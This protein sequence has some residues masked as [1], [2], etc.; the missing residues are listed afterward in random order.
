MA[1]IYI[2]VHPWKINPRVEMSYPRNTASCLKYY[3]R[4]I[5]INLCHCSLYH[6]CTSNKRCN[7]QCMY[8]IK[9]E[10][11]DMYVPMSLGDAPVNQFE[12]I[13]RYASSDREIVYRSG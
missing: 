9:V 6:T 3:H 8:A 12:I 7:P 13:I 10:V 11:A 1:G 2:L 4:Q 5:F